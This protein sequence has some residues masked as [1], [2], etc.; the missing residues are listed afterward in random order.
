MR[1]SRARER[2]MVAAL[3][4]LLG[5]IA[6]DENPLAPFDLAEAQDESDGDVWE[7]EGDDEE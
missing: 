5:T 2:F 7:E 3:E 4:K 6:D 1:Q